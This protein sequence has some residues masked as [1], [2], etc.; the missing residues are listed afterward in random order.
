[1]HQEVTRLFKSHGNDPP[2]WMEEP[3]LV[4]MTRATR[5][6]ALRARGKEV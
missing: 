5:A 4:G 3:D 2:L 6:Y 1:M